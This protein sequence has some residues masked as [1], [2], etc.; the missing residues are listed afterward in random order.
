MRGAGYASKRQEILAQRA[1]AAGPMSKAQERVMK[2]KQ[3]LESGRGGEAVTGTAREGVRRN[4][5]KDELNKDLERRRQEANERGTSVARISRYGE[6]EGAAVA[7]EKA[8]REQ[9]DMEIQK[10]ELTQL[11]SRIKD[12]KRMQRRF[13]TGI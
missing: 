10:L 12:P 2:L 8:E 11:P 5:L 7:E 4:P 1:A 3:R 9:R 6:E 13:R